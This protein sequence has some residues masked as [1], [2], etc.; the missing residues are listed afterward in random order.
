MSK[1]P[2]EKPSNLTCLTKT[3]SSAEPTGESAQVKVAWLLSL[4]AAGSLTLI[5]E[6]GRTDPGISFTSRPIPLFN[7]VRL[8]CFLKLAPT[9]FSIMSSH[10]FYSVT[11][12]LSPASQEEQ[13]LLLLTVKNQIMSPR[14]KEKSLQWQ[15][16]PE[17]HLYAKR[18]KLLEKY[19]CQ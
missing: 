16:D 3:R 18:V 4:F 11:T 6:L 17:T 19:P 13:T 14:F 10:A 2:L 9:H 7:Q 12:F 8:S 15:P 5:A 1:E